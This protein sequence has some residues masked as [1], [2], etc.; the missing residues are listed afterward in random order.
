LFYYDLW[1]RL[2]QIKY[3][4]KTKFSGILTLFLAFVVQLTF[5]QDK[6]ISGTISDENGLP[7]PGVNIVVKGTTN[8][9]QTDFDGN[10]SISAAT[11]SVIVYTFVGYQPQ[12]KTVGASSSIS[13]AMTPDVTAIEEVVIT[14]FGIKREKKEIVYQTESVDSEELTAV[15]PTTAASALAGKVAGLQINN[16]DNGV[17]PQ[18]SVVLRGLRSISGDNQALIVIDGS[19]ATS[20][21]FNALNPNDIENL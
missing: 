10:Y 9:T 13:F 4:M 7:L 1:R 16:V 19:I 15:Q 2:I 17:N 12:E 18:T 8:G 5:A 14:A 11:G 21:A 20:G 3:K 6:T